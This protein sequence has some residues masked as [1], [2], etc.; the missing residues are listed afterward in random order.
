MNDFWFK[1]SPMFRSK[2]SPND[3]VLSLEKSYATLSKI[4][5]LNKQAIENIV[6]EPSLATYKA[7]YSANQVT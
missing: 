1:L 2:Q 3:M 6:N 5:D 4:R 7:I